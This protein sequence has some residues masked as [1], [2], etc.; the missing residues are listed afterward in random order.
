VSFSPW[1]AVVMA[2]DLSAPAWVDSIHHAAITRLI[3]E[4]G[5]YPST[6][7]P[8]IDID[9]TEYHAGFHSVLASFQWLSGLDSPEAMLLLGQV[10][11]ALIVFAVYLLAVALTHHRSAGLG[12]AAI[13][14]LFTPM[15]AYQLG[16]PQLAIRPGIRRGPV[17]MGS[18][19]LHPASTRVTPLR[20]PPVCPCLRGFSWCITAWRIL[21]LLLLAFL[22]PG[23]ST[24]RR[25][26]AGN[27]S[28]FASWAGGAA[29]PALVR[30]AIRYCWR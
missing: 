15:P 17:A 29:D 14:G 4:K 13:A 3:L 6:Y 5:G 11:N 25:R 24:G 1:R 12:A 16:T 7:A 23:G 28:L 2:R 20:D 10:L 19:H 27:A 22:H 30:R 26:P 21:A 8:Y 9:A 18:K